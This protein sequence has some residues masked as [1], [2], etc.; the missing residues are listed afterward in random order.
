MYAFPVWQ[1][2]STLGVWAIFLY[3]LRSMCFLPLFLLHVFS[4]RKP[5]SL[6]IS[7]LSPGLYVFMSWLHFILGRGFETGSHVTQD[8]LDITMQ[9]R[10]TSNWLQTCTTM[11]AL[12]GVG[13]GAL[14]AP[15]MLGKQ[16]RLLS[17]HGISLWQR[18]KQYAQLEESLPTF[19]FPLHIWSIR[20]SLYL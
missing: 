14:G 8:S 3:E 11:L 4:L 15:H 2:I 7:D 5:V 1:N 9:L 13:G 20:E 16:W 17:N 12:R 6:W 10:I 18:A 19:W